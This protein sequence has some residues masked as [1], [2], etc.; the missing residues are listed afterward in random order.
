[1]EAIAEASAKVFAELRSDDEEVRAEYFKHFESEAKVFS[2]HMAKAVTAWQVLHSKVGQSERIA[3]VSAFVY[4]AITLHIHSMKLLLSG[5]IIAAGNLFRQGAETIALSLLC[6]G[7]ELNVLN[8]FI[9]DKYS[10]SNAIR[11]VLRHS[12]KLG[13]LK[14]GITTLAEA[15]NFYHK[16]SHPTK[17]TIA[18]VT[19]FSEDGLYIGA[20]FDKEKLGAYSK[21]VNGRVSLAK[22][23]YGIV[24]AVRSNVEKW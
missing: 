21:E 3:F 22:V 5:Q 10:T 8:S 18:A 7:K 11:D 20:S 24:E 1:M 9:D 19:S 13:L 2:D 17:L 4:T 23:F 16:F 6:S 12:D 14:E 15:Q